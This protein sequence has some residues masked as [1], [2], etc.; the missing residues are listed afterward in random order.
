MKSAKLLIVAF[1]LAASSSAVASTPL[2]RNVYWTYDDHGRGH[3]RFD[4]SDRAA[5]QDGLRQGWFDAQHHR[6]AWGHSK[7]WRDGDDARAYEAGYNRGY[8]DAVARDRDLDRDHDRDGNGFRD[9]DRDGDHD[10]NRDRDRDHD[11][12]YRGATPAP[13]SAPS[14]GSGYYMR[15]ARD[16]GYQ[17]G[18]KDG[19]NDKRTGH[20]FRPTQMD[21]YKN[22]DRGY[23]SDMG[24]KDQFRLSYRT[25]Y[26]SGY[27]QGWDTSTRR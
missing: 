11:H 1:A 27:K 9:H 17:D 6:H 18:I 19:A 4:D 25:G 10:G 16:T 3:D 12:D 7:K 15:T 21:N 14:S 2:L 22:A 23:R 8:R 26:S 24:E 20:S 13:A 5:Y